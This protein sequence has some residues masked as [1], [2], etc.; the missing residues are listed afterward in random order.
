MK[1]LHVANESINLR[2]REARLARDFVYSRDRRGHAAGVEHEVDVRGRFADERRRERRTLCP[3]AVARRA[4]SGVGGCGVVQSFGGRRRRNEK[5]HGR[6][7]SPHTGL[8]PAG[9]VSLVVLTHD[10]YDA[11]DLRDP[12]QAFDALVPNE[13]P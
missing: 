8:V 12:Q 11:I 3:G 5:H 9:A 2:R 10:L 6:Q 4:R 1:M 13:Q 7:E